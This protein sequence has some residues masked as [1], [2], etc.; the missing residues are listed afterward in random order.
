MKYILLDDEF[1]IGFNAVAFEIIFENNINMS[2][3]TTGNDPGVLAFIDKKNFRLIEATSNWRYGDNTDI[4]PKKQTEMYTKIPFTFDTNN[5][6]VLY[7]Q[8]IQRSPYIFYG[9]EEN[10]PKVLSTVKLELYGD[11]STSLLFKINDTDKV[12][13]NRSK[14]IKRIKKNNLTFNKIISNDFMINEVF[15]NI[16]FSQLNIELS[17]EQIITLKELLKPL[18]IKII[19]LNPSEIDV[20]NEFIELCASLNIIID[21][22][23][24]DDD[25]PIDIKLF[26]S[27]ENHG[28]PMPDDKI[29]I[30][31][32]LS[33]LPNYDF[34][35]SRRDYVYYLL[36]ILNSLN[37]KTPSNLY[38]YLS[39]FLGGK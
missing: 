14:F 18:I 9:S 5:I 24:I 32:S 37:F 31:G 34:P 30:K 25:E 27:V 29:Y 17:D 39:L 13:N 19:Y 4:L 23:L 11:V 2:I 16:L 20:K 3:I 26:T 28:P 33:N 21:P 7:M 22:T 35:Y 6:I 1:D 12:I 8:N 38:N 10:G 15:L 36:Y